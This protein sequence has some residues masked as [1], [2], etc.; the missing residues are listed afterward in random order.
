MQRR[1]RAGPSC[2]WWK[3]VILRP[4]HSYHLQAFAAGIDPMS[5]TPDILAERARTCLIGNY[6]RLPIV[7]GARR[8]VVAVGTPMGRRTST[9]SPGSAGRSSGTA[10]RRCRGG[11]RSRR[12][13][14]GTSGNTFYTEPQIEL[15]ERLNRHGVRRGRRSSA[16]AGRR[17][18]RPR[19]SWR[20][21][22]GSDEAPKRWK[23]ISLQKSF[24]GRTLAMIAA[25]G[26]PERA[27][28]LRAGC[29]GVRAGGAGRL[30]RAGG[31]GR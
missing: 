7:H 12:R 14:S 18:T 20:G 29:A 27:R 2:D 6:A 24:H 23:I 3:V 4:A 5:N 16:T 26:N 8:R 1:R 19:A 10:I 11:A 17:P 15:A 13:S 31:G 28:G 22:A 9:C 30:R 25:T 21:C